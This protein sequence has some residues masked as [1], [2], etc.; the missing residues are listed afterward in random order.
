MVYHKV[1]KKPHVFSLETIE[2]PDGVMIR[3]WYFQVES[4]EEREA[5]IKA[6]NEAA[7]ALAKS[8]AGV[9]RFL[10]RHLASKNHL[11]SMVS[12][13]QE[14]TM[15]IRAKMHERQT[16]MQPEEMGIV[17][18]GASAAA[19]LGK[20]EAEEVS[21]SPVASAPSASVTEVERAG[22]LIQQMARNTANGVVDFAVQREYM[23]TMNKI[24]QM[25]AMI[26]APGW[27]AQL[28]LPGRGGLWID[29][30]TPISPASF[31]KDV[32]TQ[33]QVIVGVSG[34]QLP[35]EPGDAL[36]LLG[37]TRWALA[38]QN[39]SCTFIVYNLKSRLFSTLTIEPNPA[40][41]PK[42]PMA[43]GFMMKWAE[44]AEGTGITA[45]NAE[46]LGDA[47]GH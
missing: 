1:I 37:S 34:K 5:W 44:G 36:E 32:E 16:A 12:N 43:G 31:C 38:E 47:A 33:H 23:Q 30:V 3:T 14:A 28:M 6:I 18:P 40:N 19:I 39:Q 8:E 11:L 10:A 9:A 26:T 4:D 29:N 35:N 2:K 25:R 13:E 15:W 7:N 21:I 46:P 24:P 17:S 22:Q 20:L 45:N 42:P 27:V 41:L